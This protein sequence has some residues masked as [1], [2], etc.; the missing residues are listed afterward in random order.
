MEVKPIKGYEDMFDLLL[1]PV[2]KY[3][4]YILNATEYVT[5]ELDT[6]IEMRVIMTPKQVLALKEMWNTRLQL[7]LLLADIE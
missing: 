3:T 5:G 7:E 6:P 4:L 1:H 2:N